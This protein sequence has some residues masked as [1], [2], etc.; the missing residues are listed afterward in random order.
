[1]TVFEESG[2]NLLCVAHI[3]VIMHYYYNIE[4]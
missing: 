3:V 4:R 1:V 2:L